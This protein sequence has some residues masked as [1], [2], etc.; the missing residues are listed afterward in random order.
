MQIQT[1]HHANA[2]II[3]LTGSLTA[4]IADAATEALIDWHSRQEVVNVVVDMT[5]VEFLDSTGLGVLIR[6]SR[7]VE[8]KD[9]EFSVCALQDAPRMVF[10][11]TRMHLAIDVFD[12]LAEALGE[13]A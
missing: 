2:G 9:G 3:R 6:L 13:A 5:A 10:S 4:E 7:H 1:Y 11:I 8:E 12:T